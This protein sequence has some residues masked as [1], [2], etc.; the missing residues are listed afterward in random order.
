MLDA[1]QLAQQ[2][3]QEIK[4]AV[5]E[6][7]QQA[8]SQTDWIQELEQQ[9][10]DFV[11]ARIYA[12]FSNIGTLPDLI[13][14]VE[15]SVTKLFEQGA[16]PGLEKFVAP[17]K[18][19]QVVDI[20]VEDLVSKTLKNLTVDPQWIT[21]IENLIL[22]RTEDRIRAKLRDIDINAKL[23]AV[24]LENRDA[25]LSPLRENFE[26]L[27]IKDHATD[28]QL[29]ILDGAVV[30]ENDL[31]A[32]DL[33][34]ERNTTLKGDV[35]ITGA[36]GIQGRINTDNETWQDLSEHVGEITYHRIKND[37]AKELIDTVIDQA[38]QG[39]D[40][41]NI[42]VD[43]E[44]LIA[45][46]TLSAGVKHSTLSSVGTLENLSVQGT[47]K[48]A[49]TLTANNRRVGI[50]TEDPE[51]ALAV[52]DEEVSIVAGKRSKDT[53]FLGTARRQNLVIGTNRQNHIEIDAEGQTTIQK[54][55][56]GRNSISWS[57]ETPNYSGTKGDLVFNVNTTPDTPFAWI[58][59]GA[60]RWQPLKA[61]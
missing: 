15:T 33:T 56:I 39:I 13:Q 59:L 49:G 12:R 44:L 9:I 16:I 23:S 27:G 25:I 38:K 5:Q 51:S 32:H 45:G 43:G 22:D 17:T 46:D 54:L 58:C 26:S 8:V 21:K 31:I 4:K 10:I 40:I 52:W 50:N 37:F 36:L 34:V 42:T 7:V 28:P 6:Q 61:Q 48:L 1:Q 19:K 14:A 47:T 53:G 24:V 20:A 30:V 60:F 35:L 11:Q 57:T 3:E 29:T 18:V 2:V 55:R 41:S